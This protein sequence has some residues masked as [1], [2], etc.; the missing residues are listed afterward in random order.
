M[1]MKDI[2]EEILEDDSSFNKPA[3]R[4]IQAVKEYYQRVHGVTLTYEQV[5][6]QVLRIIRGRI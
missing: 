5:E 1:E 6:Q 2:P 4:L 3:D